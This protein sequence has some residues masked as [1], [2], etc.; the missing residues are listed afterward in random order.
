MIEIAITD[1]HT[2]VIEG[3]RTMLKSNKEIVISQSFT[4]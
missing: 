1:D 3:I 4:N 2:I